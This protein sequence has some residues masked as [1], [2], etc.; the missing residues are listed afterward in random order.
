[1]DEP[2]SSFTEKEVEILFNVI[3]KLKK[4]NI[5]IIFISHRISEI[6]RICDTV[7]V[8]KNGCKV[9]QMPVAELT[10][11]KLVSLM[12]GRD[13]CQI[14][15]KVKGEYKK[16]KQNNL[17][18]AKNI[19]SNIKVEDV[20]LDINEGEIVGISGLLGSGRTEFA[21]AIYADEK[22]D[23]GEMVFCGQKT[24]FK[25]PKDSV[26]KGFAFCSED[27]KSEG[28]FPNMSV[29]D[30]MTIAIIDKIS[31]FGFIS[32]KKQKQITQEYI[33]KLDIKTPSI[34]QMIKNLSGGNQQKVLLARWLCKEPKLLILDEPT[35]GIDVGAK[36][37]IEELIRNTVKEGVSVMMISSELH[38]LTNG[39]DRVAVIKDGRWVSELVGKEIT[40]DNLMYAI[41]KG[42]ETTG[43]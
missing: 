38:E 16:V 31:K 35:R 27:R 41:A 7:T 6:F 13:A 8:L 10:P 22:I 34:K 3:R 28:I 42:K 19:K 17:L 32:N 23:S 21:K 5:S 12:I 39:C 14:I 37:E 1:M 26:K 9:A 2:T 18:K 20:S 24:H 30:N 11:L 33:N 36:D 40:E 43:L 29:Q 15:N 25:S 4:N